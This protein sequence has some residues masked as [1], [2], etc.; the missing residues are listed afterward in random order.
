MAANICSCNYSWHLERTK[1]IEKPEYRE[2]NVSGEDEVINNAFLD[3]CQKQKFLGSL[4]RTTAF[5]TASA[6]YF[7]KVA[8][9]G[10]CVQRG[11]LVKGKGHIWLSLISLGK[12]GQFLTFT[13]V[14]A[15]L[16]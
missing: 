7:A 13:T 9:C 12:H 6:P 1:D 15:P 4:S 14:V 2:L 8:D 11:G 16:L 5:T 10:L 3:I